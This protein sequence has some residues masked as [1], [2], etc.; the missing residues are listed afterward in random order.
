MSDKI[1]KKASEMIDGIEQLPHNA[2]F[3]QFGEKNVRRGQGQHLP[4][5]ESSGQA[6]CG[7]AIMKSAR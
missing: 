7:A 2:K 6:E 4:S 5:Q 3:P 1:H